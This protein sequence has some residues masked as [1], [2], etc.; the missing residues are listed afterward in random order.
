MKKI[1]LNFFS[2]IGSFVIIAVMGIIIPK[3][4]VISLGSSANGLL[5]SINQVLTYATLLEAGVGMASQ[6]AVVPLPRM[7]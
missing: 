1:I 2:G 6:Q 4:T 3:L 5:S 7:S